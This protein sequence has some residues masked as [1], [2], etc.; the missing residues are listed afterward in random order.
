MLV[1]V[2]LVVGVSLIV[3]PGSRAETGRTVVVRSLKGESLVL[4]LTRRQT[5]EVEGLLGTTTISIDQGM[6]MFIES[7]CPHRLCIKKGPV[8][9]VGDL[10]ACL[11]NGV[12]ARI[13]GNSDYDGITP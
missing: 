3:L 1:A 10:V 2:M 6:L 13:E 4:D 9:R 12:V 7:P 5:V 8:S 11:P